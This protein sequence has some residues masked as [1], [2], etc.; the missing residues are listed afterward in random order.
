[1]L[2]IKNL[3]FRYPSG[4][5]VLNNINLGLE[6][7]FFSLVGAS[8]CGKSTLCFALN[9]LI[10]QEI[11][12]ELSGR[13]L[14]DNMDTQKYVVRD[15]ATK[16]GMVFQ[17]PESQ[18]F[19][20]CAEDEIAFGPANLGLPWNEIE[21]RTADALKLLNIENLRTKSPEQM[22]SGE[23]QKIAIASA[24]SMNPKILVLDEPTA[25]LDPKSSEEIFKILKKISKQR[26]VFLT[27]HDID[28]V[29]QYSD[30]I[31]VMDKGKIVMKGKPREI[32]DNNLA[33][34]I[35][36]PKIVRL[37]LKLGIKPLPLTAEEM[38]KAV[39]IKKPLNFQKKT[40]PRKDKII[41][42]KN[43]C[44]EYSKTQQ[45]LKNINLSIYKGEF[46]AIVGANGSGK[47][48][49]A[50][51]LNGLLSPSKGDMIVNGANTKN[52]KV[53]ELA[54]IIGYVFQNP[55]E[56]IFGDNLIEEI[57]F[58]VKNLGLKQKEISKR[59]NSAIKY[60]GLRKYKTQDPFSLSLGQKRRITIASI[61]AMKPQVIVLDEP[62]TG[63]DLRTAENIMA[64]V[65]TLNKLGH[66]IIMI[67]H[68]MELVAEYA[69]RVIVLDNGQIISDA[70]TRETFAKQNVLDKANLTRPEINKLGCLLG[71]PKVLTINDIVKII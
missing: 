5:L 59:V 68:D 57:G 69:N 52:V 21:T 51:H 35:Y 54:K 61:L 56:Q 32:M 9:G 10:P 63:L 27:E 67:T 31:A 11:S 37:G 58:G 2:S 45:I 46:L 26:L 42:I 19:S 41:E 16:V 18:L 43:L 48:T 44:F 53:S 49:L 36:P 6:R 15:L 64:L 17:N 66:T 47:T 24:L 30:N 13:I 71:E 8:G 70:E 50:M 62:S 14:V 23:K 1:M 28:K 39:K 25:N 65:K 22:S 33:E 3:S 34:Y 60:T 20:L 12:G 29:V 55:D 7:G 38:A 40:K 4:N